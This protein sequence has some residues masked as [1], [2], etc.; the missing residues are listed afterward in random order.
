[1]TLPPEQTLLGNKDPVPVEDTV[2]YGVGVP[3]T[4]SVTKLLYVAAPIFGC[5]ENSD[6]CTK[7]KVIV[8]PG[9]N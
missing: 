3:L 6:T 9:G 2:V 1:M 8:I 7:S 5:T 4:L